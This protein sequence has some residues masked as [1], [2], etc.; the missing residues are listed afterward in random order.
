MGVS[1]TITTAVLTGRASFKAADVI[2]EET[3]KKMQ[4]VAADPKN[5]DKNVDEIEIGLTT[6]EKV[7]A[8]W[9]LYIP[10]AVAG[11]TTITAIIAAN[12]IASGKIAGLVMA[13]GVSERAFQEYK[14][15]VVEKFGAKEDKKVRDAVAQDRVNDHPVPMNS[16]EVIIAG[17]G[18]VL[19]FDALTGRYFMSSV[20]EIEKA[21][22]KVNFEIVNHMSYASLS[23]FYDKIGLPPTAYSDTVGWN[24]DNRCEVALSTVMSSDGRPCISMDFHFPPIAEYARIY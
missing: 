12:R 21:E 1:G 16:R 22:I 4:K 2:S 3:M 18:D 24:L 15:K 17:T 7:K 8:V 14:D 5:K 19:C 13:Q 23:S 11:V 6:E 10:P 9:H 20:T